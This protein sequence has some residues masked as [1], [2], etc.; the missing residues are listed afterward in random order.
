MAK[1]KRTTQMSSEGKTELAK[2]I[3]EKSESFAK[4]YENVELKISKFFRWMSGWL[5]KLL[6]NQKHGKFVALI[7]A[8]LFFVILNADSDAIFEQSLKNAETLGEYPISAIISDEAYEVTGLPETVKV[9]VIGDISDIKNVKQQKNLRIIANMTDLTEG[10]HEVKLTTEGAPS[11]VD[12]VLEPSNA[13]VTIKK[14]SIRSFTL[15]FDYVNRFKMDSIYDLSEPEL[16]QGEVYVRA[17]NE[18]LDKIAYVKAL[19]N[20]KDSYT[21]D[22]ETEATI[23]AYD[24]NGDKMDVDII[25]SKM[26]AKVKVTKPYKNVPVTL[27]PNGVIP[28]NKAIESYTLNHPTVDIFAKQSVLDNITELPISIPAST[29]TSDRE[30]SMPLIAPNGVT[31][32]SE[33]FVNISIKLAD[34]KE[35]IV[36]GVPIH[37]INTL[38]GFQASFV[39]ETDKTTAV[40]VEGAEKI[41]KKIKKDDIKVYAD[42]SK[43]DKT[44]T[45]EIELLVEGKNKLA[46]YKTKA[47]K[48]TIKVEEK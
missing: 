10:M 43:V 46:S 14:K 38:D 45:Y 26:K 21:K 22:F 28:N 9:R 5:D 2:A 18:T 47:G 30:F 41:I 27:V 7:L 36:S 40:T 1:K 13:V 20:V 16:E 6:F 42:M 37:I 12:V 11:G 4:H 23:A 32:I 34:A 15:G 31:K 25:P 24:E 39:N 33:S 48:V 17:S 29:L 35:T 3:A 19:I 44:G 8:V